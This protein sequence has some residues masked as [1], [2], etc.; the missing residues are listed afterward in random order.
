MKSKQLPY[1]LRFKVL[2]GIGA[3]LLLLSLVQYL[4]ASN[5]L[6][7]R[8]IALERRDALVNLERVFNSLQEDAEK[9]FGTTADWAEWD[10]PYNF[11]K[12]ANPDFIEANIDNVTTFE[13]LRLS[14]IIYADASGKV[15]FSRAYDLDKKAEQPVPQVLLD[16]LAGGGPVQFPDD[17][18]EPVKGYVRLPEG[19]MLLASRAVL[20]TQ[21]TGPAVGRLVMGRFLTDSEIGRVAT[22]MHMKLRLFQ[23]EDPG[24]SR[25]ALTELVTRRQAKPLLVAPVNEQ[26]LAGYLLVRDISGRPI[27][28]VS[29]TLGREIYAQGLATVHYLL[30]STLALGLIFCLLSVL[31]IEKQ[32]LS[33]LSR[34]SHGVHR[35]KVDG[36][37][38]GRLPVLPGSGEFAELGQS[39]NRML[40]QLERYQVEL[41]EAHD[42]ALAATEA[43]SR[44]LANMSHEIRTPMNGVIGMLQVMQDGNLDEDQ[45]GR[46]ATAYASAQSLLSLLNDILDFSKIEAGKLKL[47]HIDF[48]PRQIIEDVATLFAE[49]VASKGLRIGCFVQNSVPETM[50]GDPERLRQILTNLIGNAIKFTTEGYVIIRATMQTAVA[51]AKAIRFEVSDTGIGISETAQVQLFQSFTQ[52]DSSVTRKFGGTGLGLAICKQLVEMMGGSIGVTSTPGQGSSFYFTVPAVARATAEPLAPEWR[53][54]AGMQCLVLESFG[55]DAATISHYLEHAGVRYTVTTDRTQALN[56]LPERAL[57]GRAFDCLLVDAIYLA[58]DSDGDD[59]LGAIANDKSLRGLRIFVLTIAA[60]SPIPVHTGAVTTYINKPI[61]RSQLL[62]ALTAT[63]ARGPVVVPLPAPAEPSRYS[64]KVLL[65]EDNEVNQ[66]V[67]CG[68]LKKFGINPDIAENGLKALEAVCAG[69]YDLVLMDCQMPELDGYETTKRLRAREQA[70]ALPRLPIIA[71][72]ANAMSG[73]RELCLAAGMDD[74]IAK[75]ITKDTLATVLARWLPAVT[76][77]AAA[78]RRG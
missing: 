16:S 62:N 58:G 24:L 46:A 55:P 8:F 76:A 33:P 36:G 52:A 39:I 35:I 63:R 11:I 42:A 71:M 28:V 61:R 10:D 37:V 1:G 49:P 70:E 73:D 47:E 66:I 19:P 45:R 5:V 7:T 21:G 29:A 26:Q 23:T 30:I 13:R 22:A 40:D 78:T 31:F 20:T 2:F 68:M 18:E 17:P 9:I 51:N 12:G 25:I 54:L 77:P 72:T 50:Q 6:M 48:A 64:G 32:V 4:T 74:H 69:R 44:F 41:H 53:A 59:L 43:K 27:F 65:V 75:P 15:L 3:G 34:L 60:R 14:L 38:S 57:A 67:A 56:L